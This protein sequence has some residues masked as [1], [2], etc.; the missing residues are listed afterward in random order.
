MSASVGRAQTRCMNANASSA[1]QASRLGGAALVLTLFAAAMWFAWL[2]WD[3]E[4]YEVNGVM[5]GPYRPWQVIGCGLSVALGALLA[6]LWVRSAWGVLVLP[7]AAL[8]GFAVPW[9]ADAA[10]S[11][12]SGL[13]IVGLFFLVVGGGFALVTLLGVT[14]AVQHRLRRVRGAGAGASA[15]T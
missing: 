13:F 12:D 10:A 7:P 2:G 5:Q 9:T 14:A 3:H 1:R 11:D 15:T 8:L 4:Y 6:Q